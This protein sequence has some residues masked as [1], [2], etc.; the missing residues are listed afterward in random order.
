MDT[1]RPGTRPNRQ[2]GV[3]CVGRGGRWCSSARVAV[4]LLVLAG[5]ADGVDRGSA[6]D[7]A[8]G[9]SS[10]ADATS[11]T[12]PVSS[13]SPPASPSP[14]AWADWVH[15][16]I[17]DGF[18]HVDISGGVGTSARFVQTDEP[19]GG[20]GGSSA[21]LLDDG[22]VIPLPR[23]DLR[24]WTRSCVFG[25]RD[26]LAVVA[27]GDD[28]RPE[29]WMLDP[30][31]SAWSAGP[32][33]GLEPMPFSGVTVEVV[34][35]TLVITQ[36]SISEDYPE[37]GLLVGADGLIREMAAPPEGVPMFHDVF[38]GSTALTMGFE[39]ADDSVRF[40]Q[41]WSYDAREDTWQPVP[42]PPWLEC[43][44]TD[45]CDWETVGEPDLQVI[46]ATS[47]RLIIEVADDDLALLDP[48]TM[49]WTNLPEPPTGLRF[50]HTFAVDDATLVA[51]PTYQDQAPTPDDRIAVLDLGTN[52][53]V[54]HDVP[55]SDPAPTWTSITT[56]DAIL[57]APRANYET[58]IAPQLALDRHT[59]EARPVTR[60]DA[61]AWLARV[62]GPSVDARELAAAL[63]RADT[64]TP[65]STP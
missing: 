40:S 10:T 15:D 62:T 18:T 23:T 22:S 20:S 38:V 27:A 50:R 49:T 59:F 25:Q 60:A 37:Y 61:A 21:V 52:T 42:N 24:C 45:T 2:R 44:A 54:L 55:A 65:A 5:C 7:T 58:L 56:A 39:Y 63:D 9:R 1:L 8:T 29:L 19:D 28:G 17:D 57:L 32:D 36:R 6:S 4:A 13:S 46:T 41:P 11:S 3:G 34:D 48:S 51:L 53:W 14:S 12:S 47:T 33:L 30:A 43:T 31:T 26:R 64:T 35:D 16:Q